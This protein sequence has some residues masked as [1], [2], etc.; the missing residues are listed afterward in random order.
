M[1]H[2]VGE[3][4]KLF[5]RSKNQKMDDFLLSVPIFILC[6]KSPSTTSYVGCEDIRWD[7]GPPTMPMESE[8]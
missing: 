6:K 7:V 4:V 1:Q 8:G 3:M 5:L 2:F